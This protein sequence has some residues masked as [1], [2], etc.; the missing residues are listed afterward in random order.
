MFQHRQRAR[1]L[2]GWITATALV[3]VMMGAPGCSTNQNQS[4]PEAQVQNLPAV[5]SLDDYLAQ[6]S[7]GYPDMYAS[8]GLWSPFMADPFWCAPYW[9]PV[10]VF[11][12]QWQRHHFPL[13][14]AG[15]GMPPPA[16]T[17]TAA[18]S[19][20]RGTTMEPSSHFGGLGGG[21]RGFGGGHMGSGRR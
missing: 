12:G 17:H 5:G 15:Y 3:L 2:S 7:N 21:M 14:S 10:P 6:G 8:Y 11:P 13:A 9:Y 18:A 1:L 16:Q 19:A 4:T 20:E